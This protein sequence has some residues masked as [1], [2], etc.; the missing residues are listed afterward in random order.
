MQGLCSFGISAK[1]I[2]RK[3]GAFSDIKVRFAGVLF[4]GETLVTEMWKEGEKV[5]FGESAAAKRFL[6]RRALADLKDH[7]LSHKVQ[8]TRH[9]RPQLGRCHSRPVACFSLRLSRSVSC[10]CRTSKNLCNVSKGGTR[11]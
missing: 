6:P 10:C 2:F 7:V 5:V 8:G 9:C 1:H 11:L 4:P 3:F